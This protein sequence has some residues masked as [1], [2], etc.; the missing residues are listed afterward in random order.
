MLVDDFASEYDPYTKEHVN[1]VSIL[2]NSFA[3]YLQLSN[4][5]REILQIGSWLHDIGK[6]KIDQQIL[7]KKGKLTTEEFEIIKKHPIWGYE[8]LAPFGL[9]QRIME[10]VIW[11]HE[12]WDGLGYPDHISNSEI[13]YLCRILS[14]ID[15]WEA[16]TGIR[17]YRLPLTYDHAVDQLI[18]ARGSQLDPRLTE[19]FISMMKGIHTFTT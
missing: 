16:M 14:I 2:A 3:Q 6:T 9:D 11:H 4:N 10:L 5:E 19:A 15:T 18:H 8:I 12:R 17:A 13:P 1:R 7:N